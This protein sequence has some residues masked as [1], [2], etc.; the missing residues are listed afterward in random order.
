MAILI[1]SRIKT[2]RKRNESEEEQKSESDCQRK[3]CSHDR[4]LSREFA[5]ELRKNKKLWS[6]FS[7]FSDAFSAKRGSFWSK[8]IEFPLP[9][10]KIIITDS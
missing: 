5:S 9:H 7:G 1:R 4:S 2:L 6:V 3:R 10:N 8:Q